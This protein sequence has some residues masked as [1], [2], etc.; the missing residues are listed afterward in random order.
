MEKNEYKLTKG[1]KKLLNYFNQ[2]LRNEEFLEFYEYFLNSETSFRN[3]VTKLLA[4]RYGL[5][6]NLL[7]EMR[8]L[9]R[10]GGMD[11]WFGQ[12]D[13]CQIEL[14]YIYGDKFRRVMNPYEEEAF[15]IC[16]KINK[17]ASKNDIIDFIEKRWTYI[18]DYL[19]GNNVPKIFKGGSKKEINHF[20]FDKFI[21]NQRAPG[22]TKTIKKELDLKFPGN[23]LSYKE[24][25]N[26]IYQEKKKYKGRMSAVRVE[27][28]S[29]VA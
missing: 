27:S 22:I 20:I 14:S 19:R 4:Q 13:L 9:K 16:I 1:N 5:D 7:Y 12:P 26:I 28:S 24:I 6:T 23:K 11:F 10:K 21:G 18:E 3:S 15:P 17:I 8:D 25:N 2:L 29:E